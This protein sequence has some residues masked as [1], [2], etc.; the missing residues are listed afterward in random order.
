MVVLQKVFAKLTN[1]LNSP[2][3]AF[4]LHQLVNIFFDTLNASMLLL[5]LVKN[6]MCRIETLKCSRKIVNHLIL[7]ARS[8]LKHLTHQLEKM[9]LLFIDATK[10]RVH[11]LVLVK[12]KLNLECLVQ[13]VESVT[14]VN[15]LHFHHAKSFQE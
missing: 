3:D 7:L 11:H 9:P 5:E 2:F 12:T 1:N 10:E 8:L 4:F 14:L 6:G 13:Q 15:A